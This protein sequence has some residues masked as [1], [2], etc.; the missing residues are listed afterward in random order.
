MK[1]IT[2]TICLWLIL[3]TSGCDDSPVFPGNGPA[4]PHDPIPATGA[5]GQNLS[6]ILNWECSSPDDRPLTYDVYLGRETPP[7][8]VATGVAQMNYEAEN[9]IP[10]R[11]YYWRIVARDDRGLVQDGPIWYFDTVSSGWEQ[12]TSPTVRNLNGVEVS[13]DTGRAVGDTGTLLT[14][15]NGQWYESNTGLI[16]NLNAVVWDGATGYCVGDNGAILRL[17]SDGWSAETSPTAENLRAV[18][19]DNTGGAWA[20]GGNGKVL[21]LANGVWSEI[22]VPGTSG[23]SLYDVAVSVAGEV[24][25]VASNSAVFHWNGE[26]WSKESAVTGGEAIILTDLTSA[27]YLTTGTLPGFWVSNIDGDI[28]YRDVAADESVV[29]V[30]YGIPFSA[31]VNALDFETGGFGMAAYPTGKVSRFDGSG[32][33]TADNVANADLN[34]VSYLSAGVAWVVGDNGVI[35]Y[36]GPEE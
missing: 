14:L 13:G 33:A 32:W 19:F 16:D 12:V 20:V 22:Q 25:I 17:T 24:I 23:Y 30:D 11:R 26:E 35:Y 36:Y 15:V 6:L 7:P 27:A 31:S 5:T 1:K 2:I 21:R 28:I 3:I 9:L 8:L 18:T 4:V 34:D 29:W 10:N